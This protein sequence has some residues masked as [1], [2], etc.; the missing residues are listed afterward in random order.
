MLIIIEAPHIKNHDRRLVYKWVVSHTAPIPPEP[1]GS[2][3]QATHLKK[4]KIWLLMQYL[5]LPMKFLA[6]LYS[7]YPSQ[8]SQYK[9]KKELHWKV[10]KGHLSKTY[11]G[12]RWPLPG[13]N[14]PQICLSLVL[15]QPPS[16]N[17]FQLFHKDRIR[18]PT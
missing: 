4:E 2:N 6:G 15:S 13:R 7:R 3:I 1:Y 8:S 12:L 17:E 14:R 9:S 10:L 11:W 5:D 16:I 18:K